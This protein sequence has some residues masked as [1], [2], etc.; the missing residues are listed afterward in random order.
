MFPY[1]NSRPSLGKVPINVKTL[2]YRWYNS[3][4]PKVSPQM[5]PE[6]KVNHLA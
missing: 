4:Y 2:L 3:I 1:G 6:V 5:S